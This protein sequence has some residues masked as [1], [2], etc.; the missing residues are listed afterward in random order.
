MVDFPYM[1]IEQKF[2]AT[3]AVIEQVGQKAWDYFDA[4][5]ATNEVKA[6]GSVVT[7]IDK[8]IEV[9]LMAFIRELFP[10]DSIVGEEG[11]G[12][13]GTSDFVWHIDPI[14]GTDNFPRKIPFLRGICGAPRVNE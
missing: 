11:E 12:Y 14:D 3:I 10:D 9:E 1:T 6:D 2:A 8:A 7:D 5:S 13:L 4:D